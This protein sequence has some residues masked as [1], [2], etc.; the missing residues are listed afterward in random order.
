MRHSSRRVV[1]AGVPWVAPEDAVRPF[2]DSPH[3]TIFFNRLDGVLAAGG[4]E[5]AV[6]A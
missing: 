3:H 4:V 2:D 1:A 6:G 5:A